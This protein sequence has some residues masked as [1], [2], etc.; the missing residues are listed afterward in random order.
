MWRF[1]RQGVTGSSIR[2]RPLSWSLEQRPEIGQAAS[3]PDSARQFDHAILPVES[4]IATRALHEAL[5]FTVAPDALHPFGTS[6]ACV[7]FGDGTYLEPL[8]VDDAAKCARTAQ[9][10]N[11]FTA[12]DQAFRFRN[13]DEGFSAIALKSVNADADHK[14]F[15]RAGISA[16]RKLMFGRTFE[17]PNGEKERA[18][19]KLAFAADLRAP[20]FL[21]FRVQRMKMPAASSSGLTE[22]ANGVTG[23]AEIIAS[24]T[25]PS[26][27]SDFL[28]ALTGQTVDI[29]QSSEVTVDLGNVTVRV[30]T[31]DMLR[32]TFGVQATDMGRGLRLEGIVFNTPKPVPNSR[33]IGRYEIVDR[34]PGQGAFYAF[35]N[36]Q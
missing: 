5:G 21:G 22:H 6:N 11:Q 24:E 36:G 19:F 16:G 32:D 23:I 28:Q 4:L 17:T 18:S 12:R 8:A 2:V 26:D 13:G 14:A 31:P 10:G 33:K 29:A 25:N 34:A 7:F 9:K 3:M 20:D 35:M 1:T 15:Q 30:L 27:F